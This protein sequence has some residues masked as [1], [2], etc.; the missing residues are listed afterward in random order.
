M[1]C[2]YTVI[3]GDYRQTVKNYLVANNAIDKFNNIVDF[4]KWSNLVGTINRENRERFG[5]KG[6]LIKSEDVG[7]KKIL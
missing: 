5:L 1:S 6:N 7:T 3:K 2:T 4:T